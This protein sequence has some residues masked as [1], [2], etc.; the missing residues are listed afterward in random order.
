MRLSVVFKHTCG[1]E[2]GRWQR[3]QRAVGWRELGDLSPLGDKKDEKGY[4]CGSK[5]DNED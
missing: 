3:R 2:V 4:S 5:D 1:S